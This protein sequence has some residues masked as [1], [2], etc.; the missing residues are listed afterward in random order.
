MP[1]F[2]HRCADAR[3]WAAVLVV[4]ACAALIS[5]LALLAT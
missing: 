1:T 5:A 4:I 3:E 2:N